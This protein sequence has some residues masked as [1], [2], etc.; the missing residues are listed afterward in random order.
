MRLAVSNLAWPAELGD[1]AIDRLV[2]LGVTGVEV[3]PTRLAPWED[4]N[5]TLAHGYRARL[6]D[7]GLSISSLQAILYGRSELTLLGDR[8]AFAALAEHIRT[9]A[10]LAAAL[11]AEVMVLGAPRNRLRGATPIL[12]AWALGRDRLEALGEIAAASGVVI[13][14]EPVPGHYGG[15]FLTQWRDV[16]AMVREV[17][18]PGVAVHLD[19]GCVALGGDR[20][21]EAIAACRDHLAHFH[22]AQ[23]DLADFAVP[24]ANHTAA[25]AALRDVGY[26]GWVSI[27]MK[28]Q[29]GDPLGAT[30]TA[31]RAVQA[32]YDALPAAAPQRSTPF[33]LTPTLASPLVTATAA[34]QVGETN[35]A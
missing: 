21:E 27:E 5:P 14:I 24:A 10:D 33:D 7:A 3:A 30:E 11:G 29:V 22:A 13:G 4:L 6:A 12:E 17:D 32:I 35:R 2:T 31:V 1:L 34:M 28:E 18:N 8:D 20:I 19:T 23:P 15:D 16:L 26:P 25:A 9:V